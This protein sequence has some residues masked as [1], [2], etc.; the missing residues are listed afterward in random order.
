MQEMMGTHSRSGGGDIQKVAPEAEGLLWRW[1]VGEG[2]S[3]WPP[4]QVPINLIPIPLLGESFSR[5]RVQLPISGPA[6]LPL[7]RSFHISPAVWQGLLPSF[8]TLILPSCSALPPP[9]S[10]FLWPKTNPKSP[11]HSHLALTL[12]ESEP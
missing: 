8:T 5:L 2:A 7:H 9:P 11:G 3:L 4:W 6:S 10:P 12:T 1:G